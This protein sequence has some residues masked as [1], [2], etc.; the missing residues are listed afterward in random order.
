MKPN[1]PAKALPV[2]AFELKSLNDDGSFVGVASVYGNKDLG[3]DVVDKGAFTK[4]LQER[5][6]RV[7]ILWQHD[8]KQPIGYGELV[9][10]PTGLK[11][12][13]KLTLA[14]AKAAEAHALMKDDVITGL[15]IGYDTIKHKYEG[16]ARHLQELKLYEVSLVTFPMNED[17]R[18]S[19]VKKFDP[20]AVD[21]KSLDLPP[22]VHAM[23]SAA[24]KAASLSDRIA[25]AYDAVRD[26]FP[27][28]NAWVVEVYDECII[29]STGN[30]DYFSVAV[31]AWD[32]DD[33]T[34]GDVTAVE[35]VYVAAA[36]EDDD[37]E[38]AAVA[39]AATGEVKAGRVISSAN[40]QKLM[41]AQDH[42]TKA[43]EHVAAVVKAAQPKKPALTPAKKTN[44][45]Q[46]TAAV[47]DTESAD[48]LVASLRAGTETLRAIAKPSA[49]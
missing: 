24:I 40:H 7:P 18:V 30:G 32:D 8:Q 26:A 49:Q 1:T 14:V 5:G 34:L 29:V 22:A 11:I 43:A 16:G 21:V 31:T 27:L 37:L 17:A 12:S 4:T 33:P 41:A 6:S 44:R 28:T 46:P 35:K 13:G 3:G 20:A 47:T 45:R 25:G 42:L 2:F 48:V 39:S 9:D 36:G 19:D 23:V 38:N 15:S 10:T